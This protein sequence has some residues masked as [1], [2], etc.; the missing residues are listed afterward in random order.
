MIDLFDVFLLMLFATC[1]AWLWHAHGLRERALARVKQHCAKLELDL[2][3]ENV[4]LRRIGLVRDGQGHKRFA[5]IYGF[6]FTVTGEQRHD[7]TITMF[8]K[9]VGRIELAPYPML[10]S[11][12]NSASVLPQSP[13]PSPAPSASGHSG[14]VIELAQWRR[15][16]SKPNDYQSLH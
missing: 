6:E 16:H 10:H 8:G 13:E 11:V 14:N 4:A 2:L 12:D 3:D 15:E 9:H 5:R 1:C 7:G